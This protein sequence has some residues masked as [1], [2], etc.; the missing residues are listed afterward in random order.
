[1]S[2]WDKFKLT[3]SPTEQQALE[4]AERIKKVYEEKADKEYL[5]EQAAKARM[6]IG[7]CWLDGVTNEK[8]GREWTKYL[9]V[10]SSDGP[11][12]RYLEITTEVDK[13]VHM[14]TDYG[15]KVSCEIRMMT[16]SR[17]WIAESSWRKR[18]STD[19]FFRAT[20]RVI[21]LLT[22]TLRS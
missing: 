11:S 9:K 20:D 5:E 21:M 4:L 1:M 7:T 15:D 14:N 19:E 6:L 13:S 18:I 2:D 3:L 17:P 10:I 16:S 8:N 12:I 22:G